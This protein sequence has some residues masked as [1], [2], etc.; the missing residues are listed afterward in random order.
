MEDY[1]QPPL[2]DD[3]KK[4]REKEIFQAYFAKER[5]K[6]ESNTRTG[7]VWVVVVGGGMTLVFLIFYIFISFLSAL[8]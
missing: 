7:L 6:E 3:E 1:T 4:R 2:N 8:A 5:E